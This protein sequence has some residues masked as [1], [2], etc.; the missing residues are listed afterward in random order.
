MSTATQSNTRIGDF[1]VLA[2]ETLTDKEG[3]LVMMSHDTQVPEVL[4]PSAAND[5]CPYV[6][7]E[8]AADGDLVTVRPLEIGRSVRLKLSGTCNPGDYLVQA[9]VDGT[10]DGMVEALPADAGTYRVAAIAEEAGVDGQLVL[11][12]PFMLSNV[13]VN[14]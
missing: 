13:T 10:H 9:A 5:P 2:G 4:L 7:T 8:G 1:Q 3:L 12:R 6:L 11:C 14:E